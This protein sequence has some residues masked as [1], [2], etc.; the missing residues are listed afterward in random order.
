LAAAALLLTERQ[1]N[2]MAIEVYALAERY[3]FVA[4]SQ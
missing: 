4:N 1:E 3:P 2:G